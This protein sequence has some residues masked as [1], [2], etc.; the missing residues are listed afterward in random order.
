MYPC[1]WRN[2]FCSFSN[3]V[4]RSSAVVWRAR[5][6]K[7]HKLCAAI[8]LNFQV[9][10]HRQQY[11]IKA[12]FTCYWFISSKFFFLIEGFIYYLL[13]LVIL[14]YFVLFCSILFYTILFHTILHYTILYHTILHYTTLFYPILYYTL[15]HYSILYNS[16]LL[17]STSNI[18]I[19]IFY[20][21]LLIFVGSGIRLLQM[22][23]TL[24]WIGK[25]Q[26]NQP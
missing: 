13:P 5:Y 15:L 7:F 8:S 18:C 25:N 22:D 19:F 1:F 4:K 10:E 26:V 20:L 23:L 11:S 14:F 12:L 9:I 24:P 3:F 17:Y 21:H 2:V 16:I 6:A